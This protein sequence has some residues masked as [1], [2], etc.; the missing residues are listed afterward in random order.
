MNKLPRTLAKLIA[1]WRTI[2]RL[3]RDNARLSKI[4]ENPLLTGVEWGRERG[5]EIGMKGS[6]PQLLAG[7]F[8]GF[9]QENQKNAPNFI[10]IT[11]DSPEGPILVTVMQPRGATPNDLRLKAESQVRRLQS[12]L[13]RLQ[14]N[15]L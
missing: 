4:I 8:L 5:I 7:M 1:P 13:L 15:A 6:G 9:L 2:R 12:E 10:E 14:R 11:F 3:E